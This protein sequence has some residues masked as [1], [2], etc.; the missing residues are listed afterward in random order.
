MKKGIEYIKKKV[1]DFDDT[2][3]GKEIIRLFRENNKELLL[4]YVREKSIEFGTKNTDEGLLNAL[5]IIGFTLK[6]TNITGEDLDLFYN[7]VKEDRKAIADIIACECTGNL[8]LEFV[9]LADHLGYAQSSEAL[10]RCMYGL[11]KEESS[12]TQNL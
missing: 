11:S 10:A 7:I 8:G 6:H 3:I 4:E 1:E 2:D 12:D 5:V 9:S